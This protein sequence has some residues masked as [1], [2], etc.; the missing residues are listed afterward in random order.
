ML[1]SGKIGFVCFN[2]KVVRFFIFKLSFSS[3]DELNG[4]ELVAEIES[5]LRSLQVS[6]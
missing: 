2:V 6:K 1:C 4:E 5:K 3:T